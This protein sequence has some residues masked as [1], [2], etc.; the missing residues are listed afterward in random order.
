MAI[1]EKTILRIGSTE[2]DNIKA[3]QLR[4]KALGYY[5]G[6]IDGSFGTM[7]K[8]AVMNY[9]KAKFQS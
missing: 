1:T 7:T 5:K 3:L 9:Q 6:I 4:L 2:K 8:T